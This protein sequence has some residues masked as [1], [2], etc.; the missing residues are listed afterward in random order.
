LPVEQK[1]L[2]FFFQN[3][4]KINYLGNNSKNEESIS[5]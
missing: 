5:D 3:Q 4:E 1:G 2:P